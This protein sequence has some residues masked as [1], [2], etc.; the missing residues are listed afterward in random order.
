MPSIVS[1]E[2][3]LSGLPSPLEGEG[4]R[5]ADEGYGEA[6]QEVEVTTVKLRQVGRS[7]LFAVPPAVTAAL[8]LKPGSM[9]DVE[10]DEG[11]LVAKRVRPK[12]TIEELIAKCDFNAPYSDEEREWI[13]APPVGREII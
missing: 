4:A 5:R 10:A 3:D 2:P 8:G 13:D 9:L 6:T 1:S 7:L 12:Y 11:R